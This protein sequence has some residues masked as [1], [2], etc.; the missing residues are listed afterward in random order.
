MYSSR[1]FGE[2]FGG[3]DCGLCTY[4]PSAKEVGYDGFLYEATQ[5][6]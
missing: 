1:I 5:S 4:N 2:W 6:F 3:K